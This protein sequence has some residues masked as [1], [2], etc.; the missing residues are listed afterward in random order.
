[1]EARQLADIHGDRWLETRIPLSIKA[2]LEES[3]LSDKETYNQAVY[4]KIRLSKYS[5]G[6]CQFRFC[7]DCLVARH[8]IDD[9]K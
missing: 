7:R 6:N 1:M 5:I 8:R 4:N 3:S 2:R 9:K